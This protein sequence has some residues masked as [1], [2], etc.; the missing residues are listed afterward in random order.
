MH[1]IEARWPDALTTIYGPDTAIVYASA[2]HIESGWT[3]EDMIG[4]HW[5]KFVPASDYPHG[6]L[7]LEDTLLN[8]ESTEIGVTGLTKSGQQVRMRVKGWRMQDPISGKTY[9]LV[10]SLL[11]DKP[12]PP[13]A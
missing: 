13:P 11:L 2:N 6:K 3:Q 12:L 9:V 8:E 7:A 4:S 5:T 1:E 10:R